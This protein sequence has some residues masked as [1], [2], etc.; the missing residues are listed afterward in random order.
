MLV[1][2]DNGCS[3]YYS[4]RRSRFIQW[5]YPICIIIRVSTRYKK[6]RPR[7][8]IK[9]RQL[10]WCGVVTQLFTKTT[11]WSNEQRRLII[12][13]LEEGMTCKMVAKLTESKLSSVY[14]I[15][16]QVQSNTSKLSNTS[17]FKSPCN[18][19]IAPRFC[20][21]SYDCWIAVQS[22]IKNMK[23][24][25]GV[26]PICSTNKTPRWRGNFCNR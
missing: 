23:I 21:K 13:M 6:I 22:R 25:M 12:A 14:Y 8:V 18:R 17:K 10:I 11:M 7:D 3:D 1:N 20:D 16:S 26:C 24:V 19:C 2:A 15:R 9:A 4:T 5:N